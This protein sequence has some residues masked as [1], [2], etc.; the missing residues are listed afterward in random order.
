MNTS[1][2]PLPLGKATLPLEVRILHKNARRSLGLGLTTR[3]PET[4][5]Q[6]S[7]HLPTDCKAVVSQD[8]KADHSIHLG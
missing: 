3:L 5:L 4:A 7:V 1:T 6:Q 2:F 8:I